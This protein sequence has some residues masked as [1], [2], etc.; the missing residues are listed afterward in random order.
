MPDYFKC[1]IL[2]E[3]HLQLQAV[4]YAVKSAV[5]ISH[6]VQERRRYYTPLLINE[7]H[8][9]VL[10][11]CD[12]TCDA[13]MCIVLYEICCGHVSVCPLSRVLPKWLDEGSYKQQQGLL[14]FPVPKIYTKL[15]QGNSQL[16]AKYRWIC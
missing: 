3:G 13:A 4:A 7:W 9:F 10:L 11:F 15:Q 5:V 6:T 8:H 16:D 1:H 2:A 12:Q 14:C